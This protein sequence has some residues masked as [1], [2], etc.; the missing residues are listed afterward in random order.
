MSVAR[1][2]AVAGSDGGPDGRVA[3]GAVDPVSDAGRAAA[4]QRRAQPGRAGAA[5]RRRQARPVGTVARRRGRWRPAAQRRLLPAGRRVAG[6]PRR[7][8]EHQGGPAAHARGPRDPEDARRRQ[9]QGQP[10]GA[11][12]ADGHRATAHAGRA[13]QVHPDAA[14]AGDPLRGQLRAARD[15]HRR[16]RPPYRRSAALVQRLLRGPVGRRHAGRGDD[17][18]QATAAGWTS[19]AARCRTPAR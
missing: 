10:R 16:P 14:R 18:I 9:Q 1:R 4:A 8:A 12:P 15:L 3:L 6:I 5:H 13:A 19:S 11:L 17:A 2:M 7:G